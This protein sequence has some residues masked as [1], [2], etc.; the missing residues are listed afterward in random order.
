[1][2]M[3]FSERAGFGALPQQAERRGAQVAPL[4]AGL[5]FGKNR[6]PVLSGMENVQN[7]DRLRI[8]A[9]DRNVTVPAVSEPNRQVSKVWRASDLPKQSQRQWREIRR[10]AT[11]Q[12]ADL[13]PPSTQPRAGHPNR[14]CR[15]FADGETFLR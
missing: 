3:F 11:R 5:L 14:S 8:D 10:H 15:R 2:P 6:L 4:L 1:M 13:T 7:S 9:V 12:V